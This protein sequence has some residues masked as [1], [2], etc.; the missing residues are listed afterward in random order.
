MN[1]VIRIRPV[2]RSIRRWSLL[3]FP[4]VATIAARARDACCG[5]C[6]RLVCGGRQMLA[7]AAA[8]WRRWSGEQRRDGLRLLLGGV[9]PVAAL[10][11]VALTTGVLLYASASSAAQLD[12]CRRL[13]KSWS[14]THHGFPADP[15]TLS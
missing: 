4:T 6:S 3:Q 14:H 12:T 15:G 8:P 13:R 9:L 5:A 7:L 11:T 1:T 10:S 2:Q